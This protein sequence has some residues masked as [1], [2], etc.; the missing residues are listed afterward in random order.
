MRSTT[1][2]SRGDIVVVPYPFSEL[3][4]IKNRPA[5]VLSADSFLSGRQDVVIAAI[6]SRIGNPPL[7]GDHVL[8]DWEQAGL[9]RPSVLTGLLRTAKTYRI[10]RRM[11]SIS[12][13]DLESYES[14]LRRSLGL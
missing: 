3:A 9:P 2:F 5:L 1:T 11:G 4:I 14:I 13:Y 10:L 8:R 6:T 7:Y 12:P